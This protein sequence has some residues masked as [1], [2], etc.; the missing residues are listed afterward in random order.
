MLQAWKR[1]CEQVRSFAYSAAGLIRRDR[2]W[3][4][5]AFRNILTRGVVAVRAFSSRG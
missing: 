4:A 5:G 3:F 2:G 1:R